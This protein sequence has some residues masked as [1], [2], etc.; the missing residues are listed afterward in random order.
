LRFSGGKDAPIVRKIKQPLT[1]SHGP[2]GYYRIY[3]ILR[4]GGVTEYG[5]AELRGRTLAERARALIAVADPSFQP[6]LVKASE[7]LL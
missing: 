7:R 4:S 5:T 1:A 2:L 6:E 3:V